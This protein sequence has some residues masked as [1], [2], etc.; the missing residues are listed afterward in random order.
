MV[1][2]QP[3]YS[4]FQMFDDLVLLAKGGLTVYHGPVRKVEEYFSGLG[5]NV[6][7]RV[8]PPD[9]FCRELYRFALP[10]VLCNEHSLYASHIS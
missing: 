7:D 10:C 3:S 2:H 4:L 8:N 5:I 9:F 1:V 6:P